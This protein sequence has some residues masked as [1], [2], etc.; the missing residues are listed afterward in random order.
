MTKW[1][2]CVRVCARKCGEFKM[3][4]WIDK[5]LFDYNNEKYAERFN[6]LQL[7]DFDTESDLVSGILSRM[8]VECDKHHWRFLFYPLYP[9]K[10]GVMLGTEQL[11]FN[12]STD[13]S[14]K[15]G[16]CAV[17]LCEDGD[18]WL[19]VSSVALPKTTSAKVF[20][21]KVLSS[22]VEYLTRFEKDGETRE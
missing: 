2:W 5:Y 14:D 20:V 4:D 13:V 11:S 16:T 1:S 8:Q 19:V 3:L 9:T 15:D 18:D 17:I 22:V 7:G 10:L 6:K 21:D 12:V